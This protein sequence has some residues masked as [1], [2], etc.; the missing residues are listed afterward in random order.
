MA[1][2][3][4]RAWPADRDHAVAPGHTIRRRPGPARRSSPLADTAPA[5][6]GAGF[7]CAYAKATGAR[8]EAPRLSSPW[9]DPAAEELLGVAGE[10]LAAGDARGCALLR[11]V[12]ERECGAAFAQAVLKA[13]ADGTPPEALGLLPDARPRRRGGA[14]QAGAP[15]GRAGVVPPGSSQ[16]SARMPPAWPLPIQGVGDASGPGRTRGTA[17]PKPA[18]LAARAVARAAVAPPPPLPD[19][20]YVSARE[21]AA[22]FG[23]SSKAVYRWMASGRVVAE[24]RPGG[25]Y[26]I[27]VE[28]FHRAAA[29]RDGTSRQ[30]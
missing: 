17:R 22:H 5:G 19:S 27:P 12:L 10:L 7:A 26:R 4:R 18:P 6:R 25:S 9:S 23:V 14:R 29:Q 3:G 30:V 16:V 1:A 13:L 2:D 21:L 8:G 15:R 11:Y 20:G 24:R 28:Q